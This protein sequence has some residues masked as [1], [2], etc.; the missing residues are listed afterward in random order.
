LM[1]HSRSPA[2]DYIRRWMP[3]LANVVYVHTLES[4]PRPAIRS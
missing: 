2:G 3:E 4:G 1:C